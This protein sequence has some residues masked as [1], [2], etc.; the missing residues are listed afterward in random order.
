M[1]IALTIAESLIVTIA[2]QQTT[3]MHIL[4][5]EQGLDKIESIE[6][7]IEGEDDQ[8]FL[9]VADEEIQNLPALADGISDAAD[10]LTT[11]LYALVQ[12]LKAKLLAAGMG[13]KV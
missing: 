5:A 3:N 1:K 9:S 13:L 7:S 2:I 8:L 4:H 6:M 12:P 11:E 10:G